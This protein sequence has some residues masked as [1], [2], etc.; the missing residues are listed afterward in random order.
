MQRFFCNAVTYL[1]LL[2]TLCLLFTGY[3]WAQGGSG[4]LSGV[5]TDPS[6]AV[7]PDAEV[8]LS[9]TAT[10]DKR[11]TVTTGAGIYRFSALPVGN[12]VLETSPQGF[13]STKVANVV[14]SVGTGT[15]RDIHLELGS[16]SEQVTVEAGAQML[17]TE[18]SSVSQLIDRRVW[19]NMPLEARNPND[20]VNLVAGA[21]PEE[22]AGGTL[23]G[24]AGSGGG[25]G[26]GSF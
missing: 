10:G 4:E 1:L 7:I 5:V 17:Q 21:V 18:D 15:V 19:E 20:F 9:N 11:T 13:K 2:F 14:V 12:Y 26:T 6:G 3:M 25:T 22:L 8:T 24:A 23:R 16:T